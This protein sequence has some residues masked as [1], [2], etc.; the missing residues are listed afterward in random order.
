MISAIDKALV[1]ILVSAVTWL[2]Q[3]Y[4]FHLDADP[5]T[6]AVLVGAVSSVIV[7]F[8]PNKEAAK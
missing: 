4:G 1:P 8:I 6:L 3:K 2:N 5:S 7:Y